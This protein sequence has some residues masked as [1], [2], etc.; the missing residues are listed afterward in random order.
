MV[1]IDSTES[2]TEHTESMTRF[3]GDLPNPPGEGGS[4]LRVEAIRQMGCW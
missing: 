1:R 2:N 4:P 3:I